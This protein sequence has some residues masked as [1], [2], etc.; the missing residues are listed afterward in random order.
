MIDKKDIEKLASLARLKV[1]D[2]LKESLATSIESILGYVGQVTSIS[3]TVDVELPLVRNVMREDE[4][5][6]APHEFSEDLLA[7]APHRDGEYVEVK[8]ILS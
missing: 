1:S 7:L 3:E 2:N 5:R 8:K 4:V 6:H